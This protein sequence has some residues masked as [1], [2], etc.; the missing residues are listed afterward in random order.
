M[1]GRC[2]SR[3]AG[4]VRLAVRSVNFPFPSWSSLLVF[5]VPDLTKERKALDLTEFEMNWLDKIAA[6]FAVCDSQL[7]S[8][9]QA[10]WQLCVYVTSSEL[11]A[12]V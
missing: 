8:A 2:R 10:S 9:F 4:R 3:M 5:H 11:L 12:C 1:L 6:T 7:R